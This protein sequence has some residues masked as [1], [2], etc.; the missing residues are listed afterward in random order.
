MTARGRT[1]PYFS[2]PMGAPDPNAVDE[3]VSPSSFPPPRALASIIP[4]AFRSPAA[5]RVSR[6]FVPPATGPAFRA[7]AATIS[8]VSPPI[9]PPRAHLTFLHPSLSP[10]SQGLT[11]YERERAEKIARNIEKM[12]ALGLPA[13]G[14]LVGSAPN[15]A[16][17][18]APVRRKNPAN[19]EP[20]APFRIVLRDRTLKP[21]NYNV[22][23]FD[24]EDDVEDGRDRKR[25]RRADTSASPA[26]PRAKPRP[27]P[28]TS[29]SG[30][31][32]G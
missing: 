10:A 14:G 12:K 22:D 3:N 13:L 29:R 24:P 27:R 18:F 6:V 1:T 9:S 4:R 11:P 5:S 19:T 16:G 26:K 28:A 23:S 20:N 32:R 8:G 2:H 30:I 31:R 7:R 21:V 17:G 15:T 25:S